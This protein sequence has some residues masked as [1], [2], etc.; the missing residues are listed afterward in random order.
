MSNLIAVYTALIYT[1]A[2]GA[3][4]ITIAILYERMATDKD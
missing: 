4:P 2:L 1:Y 3:I